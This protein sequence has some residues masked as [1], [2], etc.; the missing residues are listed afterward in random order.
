MP[1]YE[2]QCKKCNEVNEAL[3]KFSD[4]PPTKC[5]H[6]G[7][8]VHKLMSLNAFQL[9]GSGWYITDYAGK[10]FSTLK[11]DCG[12]GEAP[13]ES[14]AKTESKSE[15]KAESTTACKSCKADCAAS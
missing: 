7:G 2:Y 14:K 4:P 3:Q 8:K 6:C 11:S 10:N 15:T 12:G 13:G 5:P 1:I 9:K